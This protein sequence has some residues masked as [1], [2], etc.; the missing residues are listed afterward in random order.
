MFIRSTFRMWFLFILLTIAGAH[1]NAQCTANA[2]ND[3]TVCTT[4][5]TTDSLYLGGS[6][7]ATGSVPPYT[8][9]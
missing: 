5:L 7:T 6:P 4:S 8:Y 9:T 1:L 2:G 3:T